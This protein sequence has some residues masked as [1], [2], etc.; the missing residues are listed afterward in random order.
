MD[1]RLEQQLQRRGL[2]PLHGEGPREREA[3]A[4]VLRVRG[5]QLRAQGGEPAGGI[6]PGIG[7]FEPREGQVGALR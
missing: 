6:D 1:Q 4:P 3:R 7:L 5:D 2:A